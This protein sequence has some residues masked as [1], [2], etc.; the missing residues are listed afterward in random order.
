MADNI[1][2]VPLW[3]K[4]G[5]GFGHVMNDM[6]ASMWFTYLLLFFHKVLDFNNL[7]AGVILMIGNDVRSKDISV[8][9]LRIFFRCNITLQFLGQLADGL[10]TV[11]VGYFSDTNDDLW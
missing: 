2:R 4:I 11:F 7:G 9:L 5:F 6:C 3:T 10:S 8:R 1:E